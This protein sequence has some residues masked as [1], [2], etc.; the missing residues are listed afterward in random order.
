[1]S[2]SEEERKDILRLLT[3]GSVDDGK[4]TLMGRLLYD[5][6]HIYEDHRDSLERDSAR[7]GWEKG[8]LDYSL[9][10][11]GLKAEREQNITIDLAYRYF[12]TPRRKFIIA[13]APGHEQYTQ[14]MATGASNANLLL[15]LVSAQNGI[16][17]QTLRHS[18]IASLMGIRHFVVAVNKM[19]LV[20][21]SQA[22]FEQIKKEYEAFSARLPVPDIH[23][24]PL[25][26][27][28]GDNVVAP[29]CHMPWHHGTPLLEYLEE[30]YIAGDRN[31]IDLRFPVQLVLRPSPDFRG[32]AGTLASGILRK[33]DE[34]AAFP[35]GQKSRV[36]SILHYNEELPEAFAPQ[37]ITV[38]LEDNIDISRGD[39]LVHPRNQPRSRTKLEAM[40]IWMD[41]KQQAVPGNSWL[42]KHTTNTVSAVLNEIVYKIDIHTLHRKTEQYGPKPSLD[43]N[44]I[45][46]VRFELHRPISADTYDVNRSTGSFILIDPRSNQTVAAGMVIDRESPP[47]TLDEHHLKGTHDHHGCVVWLTGL[48]GSGKTT[49][50]RALEKKLKESGRPCYVL[51]GDEIRKGLSKDLGFSHEDRTE[52]VRRVGEVAALLSKAGLAAIVALISPFHKDRDKAR[53]AAKEG[54]FLE[55]FLDSPLAVCEARDPK[56]LYER[57]RKG[58][59]PDFTGISA[60]YEPPLHPDLVLNTEKMCL[61]EAVAKILDLLPEY[62]V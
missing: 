18:Y 13:D 15:L 26:A 47:E 39:M 30:V 32:Y 36:C 2:G 19:D 23:F 41:G 34:V 5:G 35:S 12:A 61:D 27:A 57:A 50:A 38:V 20:D 37:A 43:F 44:D 22:V 6:R 60:P 54:C 31:L 52:H 51:D 59:I 16:V 49:L 11:D 7:K 42:L 14:N 1:M 62:K 55:I 33:G 48:S 45:A 17:A 21:Y 4:S 40:I 46:R 56:G 10:L 3:A 8:R 58:E 9:L 28:Q 29:S 25:S 24:I 53:E